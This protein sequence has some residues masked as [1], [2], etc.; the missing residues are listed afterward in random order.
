[1]KLFPIGNVCSKCNTGSIDGISYSVFE[2][3]AGCKS[4]KI[5]TTLLTT[6]Q[7]QT[8]L[9]RK[10]AEPYLNIT[11]EYTYIFD[12]EY[13]QIE[14]FVD[15]VDD[16]LTSFYTIDWS[17]GRTPSAVASSAGIWTVSIDDTRDYS[18]TANKKS[19]Y[20]FVWNGANW[21]MGNVTTVTKKTSI[22]VTMTPYNRGGLLYSSI[23]VN[24]TM[25]YPVY[26]VRLSQNA[27]ST[28]ERT[29]YWHETTNRS[30]NGG[31]MRSGVVNFLSKYKVK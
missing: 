22:A 10:K 9:S 25:V 3:N 14:H 17:R 11:Y 28:F 31:F 15:T 12:R 29:V 2:P 21:K 6:F 1:M 5:Y 24:D 26:E 16:A 7:D 30:Q 4:S 8:I 23:V 19:N 27:L 20:A 18:A 13:K